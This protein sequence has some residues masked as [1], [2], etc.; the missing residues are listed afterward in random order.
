MIEEAQEKEYRDD[1]ARQR[2]KR[3][4]FEAAQ[5][6][7]WEKEKEKHAE[8]DKRRMKRE[9]MEFRHS[10]AQKKVSKSVFGD[11]DDGLFDYERRIPRR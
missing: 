8:E 2:E 11:Q 3:K 5:R 7:I 10:G 1:L 4:V 6:A 9:Y